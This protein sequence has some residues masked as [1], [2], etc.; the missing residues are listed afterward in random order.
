MVL[1][2]NPLIRA[3]NKDFY[4][5][6]VFFTNH[7]FIDRNIGRISRLAIYVVGLNVK[8]LQ[9][10]DQLVTHVILAPL[11]HKRQNTSSDRIDGI[12]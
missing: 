12:P 7:R 11:E 3:R 6:H 9:V 8:S 5:L 2:V 10:G 1:R 4:F